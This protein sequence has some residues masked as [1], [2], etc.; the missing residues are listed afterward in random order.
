MGEKGAN[1]GHLIVY[2]IREGGAR[3]RGGDSHALRRE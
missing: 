2:L 3:N 1:F